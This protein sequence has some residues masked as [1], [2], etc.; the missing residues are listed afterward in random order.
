MTAARST[1]RLALHAVNLVRSSSGSASTATFA[2]GCI[3]HPSSWPTPPARTTFSPPHRALQAKAAILPQGRRSPRVLNRGPYA[4]PCPCPYT[5]SATSRPLPLVKL[6]SDH[7]GRVMEHTAA[8]LDN[9]LAPPPVRA[10]PRRIVRSEPPDWREHRGHAAAVRQHPREG[11]RG[12]RETVSRRLP[13]PRAT[14]RG[15]R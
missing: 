5:E 6:R 9:F 15:S 10:R 2:I 14:L 12:R 11:G 3:G 13:W 1:A 4:C 7:R 8:A